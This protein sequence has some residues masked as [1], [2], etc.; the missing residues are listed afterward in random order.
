MLSDISVPSG[1]RQ[2]SGGYYQFQSP[3][4]RVVPLKRINAVQQSPIV[5]L[6]DKILAAKRADPE[7]DISALER[8]IDELVYK[9]YGLTAEEI[10]IV[11]GVNE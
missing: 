3:Q 11:K 10:K 8:K 6:V 5:K 4:L 9:L 2:M 7:A 1:S